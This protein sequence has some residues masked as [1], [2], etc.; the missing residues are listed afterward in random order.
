MS[1]LSEET[2]AALL[3][4]TLD[5]AAE[6]VVDEHLAGCGACGK[7]VAA[8][9]N[10]TGDPGAPAERGGESLGGGARIG[11]YEVL[12]TLGA[13]G[14]GIV[15][16]ARDPDLD[17]RVALKFL[18]SLQGG[19]EQ[20]EGRARVLR[21]AQAMARLS[22]PNVVAVYDVG[23]FRGQV[24]IA[25]ELIEGSTLREWLGSAK[26]RWPE[27]LDILLRAGRGLAAAHAAGLVHRDFKPENVLVGNDGRVLV[28]DF[29]L[30]RRFALGARLAEPV[31]GP[32][33]MASQGAALANFVLAPEVSTS[34]ASISTELLARAADPDAPTLNA[35]TPD[36]S[37]LTPFGALRG[38]PAYMAPEQ[39]RGE[40]A[41]KRSDLFS[42]C[43]ALYEGVAGTRPYPGKDFN[44]LRLRIESGAI[45]EPSGKLPGWLRRELWRG[46][47]P[48][49]ARRH[50]SM[51]E[52]LDGLQRGAAR[53]RWRWFLSAA[54]VLALLSALALERGRKP[55]P[56]RSIAVVEPRD[57]SPS[58][59]SSWLAGAI[60]ELLVTELSAAD[61]L[62][63]I[64]LA[65]VAPAV[66]DVDPARGLPLGADAAHRL[67]QRLG[68]DL[69]LGGSYSLTA[70]GLRVELKVFGAEALP[71]AEGEDRATADTLLPL[72]ARLGDR[73]RRALGARRSTS[74]ERVQNSFP[75]NA[76]AAELYVRGLAR[77][78]MR[79][80][81]PA[82]EL[83]QKAEKLSSANPRIDAALAEALV[84]MQTEM[85][86][87]EPAARAFLHKNEL[88]KD[89]RARL[90][91]VRFRAL[92]DS[93][94][95]IARARAYWREAPDDVERGLL[96]AQ[97][98]RLA[99]RYSDL[100][101]TV[102]ELRKIPPPQG[103]DSRIDLIEASATLYA[104]NL[105]RSVA[106]ARQA[107]TAAEARGARYEMAKARYL[108]GLALARQGDHA[109]ARLRLEQSE[110]LYREARDLAG[111]EG[112]N[113][114][115]AGLQ[116]DAGDL[117]GARARMETALAAFRQLGDSQGEQAVLHNL[118][119]VLRRMRDLPAAI[120]RATLA[121]TLALEHGHRM[122][123]A[124]N[125]DTLGH[126]RTDA[127]YLASAAAAFEQSVILHRELKDPR[128]LTA[129]VGLAIVRLEQ[130][131]LAEAR[132][133]FEE[134]RA[135]DNG[136]EKLKAAWIRNLEAAIDFAEGRLGEALVAA[137]QAATLARE[138]AH[139]EET[140]EAE[141]LLARILLAQGSLQESRA[142]VLRARAACERGNGG[143]A[144]VQ[145][146]IAEGR[147]QAKEDPRA[148]GR[149]LATLRAALDEANRSGFVLDQWA[150][151]LAL[152]ELHA[153]GNEGLRKLA[154]E[155]RAE[156]FGLV[157]RQAE[158]AGGR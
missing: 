97:Q 28:T 74:P 121:Q 78:R 150:A 140:A 60:A 73:L 81:G 90:E 15:Y 117:A 85:R 66:A 17:R 36:L 25:M 134:A 69:I 153:L 103:T 89:D 120:E 106:T 96:V 152:A 59:S 64:P 119:I 22:H 151:R 114:M 125:L 118:A 122:A 12:G 44:Q 37:P 79:E 52:L 45:E 68:A 14:M 104:G 67:Q 7:L 108:E 80:V 35:S 41:T 129:L 148:R 102:G 143:I 24:F 154:Q 76:E 99:G 115:L 58:A 34:S 124:N 158:A 112:P 9:A 48:D 18:H 2:V 43:T 71:V 94:Q 77:L 4:G 98:Q 95:A 29:G 156:G 84:E 54:V 132:R 65:T 57:A 136:Q 26:R 6:S 107:F 128:V 91:I 88:P 55:P 126:L 149:A 147:L 87:S 142:A 155:A 123:A 72:T 101:S 130:G 145:V 32:P 144:R 127:G 1:C 33:L 13:G 46:L 42:F 139:L 16:A 138:T 5:A 75:Q 157:A 146:A 23:A 19:D 100:L 49:P 27:V 141:V 92:H 20:A 21:E 70:A 133:I 116:A 39:M 110:T 105:P 62:R 93:E 38:T 111:A 56:R 51:E 31:R 50:A 131:D 86:A 137:G 3:D 63:L 30:A 113:M 47:Q 11:R 83:L 53:R 135:A 61:E 109:A 10:P 40:E 82:V 8:C